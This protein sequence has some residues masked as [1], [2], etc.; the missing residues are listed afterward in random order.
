MVRRVP[1][2]EHG[3]HRPT[4]AHRGDLAI[5]DAHV[6]VEVGVGR[7]FQ[8]DAGLDLVIGV[9]DGVVIFIVLVEIAL[10]TAVRSERERGCTGCL[11]QPRGER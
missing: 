5:V 1:R 4:I 2:S 6:G 3:T 9:R 8:L 7:L 11:A 10:D